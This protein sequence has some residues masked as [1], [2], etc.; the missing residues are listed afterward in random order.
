MVSLGKSGGGGSTNQSFVWDKQSPY[1]ENL[2]SAGENMYNANEGEVSQ[3]AG[4]YTD[5]QMPGM[6]DAIAGMGDTSFLNSVKSGT[7]L[8]MTTMEGMMNPQ[9]NPYL[10]SQVN[11]MW[12]SIGRNM[13][14][15]ILPNQRSEASI[16]GSYGGSRD[17]IAEGMALQEA[18]RSGI[19]AEAGLRFGAYS[20]DQDRALT[21]AGNYAG[22]GMTA[23]QMEA[24]RLNATP[25]MIS[26]GYNLGMTPYQ[27]PFDYLQNYQ[28]T[29]GQPTVLGQGASNQNSGFSFGVGG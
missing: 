29:I 16:R 12:G 21:A 24:A 14:E 19:D 18:T 10:D 25:E 7:N 11:S 22:A 17:N 13:N 2:Y 8:G 1:L 6:Q 5:Q 28:N 23:D 3:F 27:A 15:N 9:G 4:N 20:G 26:A